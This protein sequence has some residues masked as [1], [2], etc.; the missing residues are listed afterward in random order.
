MGLPST[1]VSSASFRAILP[2][3]GRSMR[4]WRC[5]H[6]KNIACRGRSKLGGSGGMSYPRKSWSLA[7]WKCHFGQFPKDSSINKKCK[8]QGEVTTLQIYKKPTNFSSRYWCIRTKVATP[9]QTVL[10][11][12][13]P[14]FHSLTDCWTY[15][16]DLRLVLVCIYVCI[17]FTVLSAFF[18]FSFACRLYSNRSRLHEMRSAS[19]DKIG[20]ML[21]MADNCL[22]FID[23]W[24]DASHGG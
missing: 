16:N 8:I 23:V 12:H 24:Q 21:A 18:F 5:T 7:Y 14:L 3:Q 2:N 15:F 11:F 20:F 22:L 10:S 1:Y 9:P 19:W 4:F 6:T 13:A 17:P